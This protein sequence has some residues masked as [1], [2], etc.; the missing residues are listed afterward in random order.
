MIK[1]ILKPLMVLLALTTLLSCRNSIKGKVGLKCVYMGYA[2]GECEPK[3]KIKA[4]IKYD[5]ALPEGIKES[6]V[7]VIFKT[8]NQERDIDNIV[9]DCAICYDYYFWGSLMKSSGK[10]YYTINVDS[11]RVLLRDKSCCG[12][13]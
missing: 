7:E 8:S 6:D 12:K 11:V 4:I 5:N 9:K 1:K 3:Y 10:D 2:C 13:S